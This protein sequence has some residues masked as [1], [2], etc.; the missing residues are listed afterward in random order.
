MKKIY[1]F[2]LIEQVEKYVE[3]EAEN[4]EEAEML[5]SNTDMRIEPDYY[6][7]EVRQIEER[8]IDNELPL[9]VNGWHLE[10][11]E[12][13]TYWKQFKDGGFKAVCIYKLE[14]TIEDEDRWVTNCGYGDTSEEAIEQLGI[15]PW[16]FSDVMTK[17]DVMEALLNYMRD[18]RQEVE[19]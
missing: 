7:L 12:N 5:A 6:E 16:C 14:D 10:Y 8:F 13:L 1:K 3:V 19:I 11:P 9:I 2:H 17:S 15:M 18:K 4:A